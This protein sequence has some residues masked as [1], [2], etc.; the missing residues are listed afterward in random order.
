MNRTPDI[1]SSEGESV[2]KLDNKVIPV[3]REAIATVQLI[4]FR[5]LKTR[6][7]AKYASWAPDE[8]FRLVGCIVNDIFGTPSREKDA[9]RF[10]R[11]HMDI[12]EEEMRS[13]AGTVP[14]LLPCLADAL[15]MQTFCDYEEG[16]NSL[17]TLLRARAL[18]YLQ[19]ERT[20][21]MPSTFMLAVRRLGVEHG[22]LE[23]LQPNAPDEG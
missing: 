16:V 1:S 2:E 11:L 20:M 15:R 21:P 10:A 19:E 18:G 17:P 9:A 22:L 12:V 7:A 3:M 13:L 6:L 8:Y 14:G 23:E 5:E 4:L